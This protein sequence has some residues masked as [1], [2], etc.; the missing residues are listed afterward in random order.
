MFTYEIT[1]GNFIDSHTYGNVE[2]V[3]VRAN[4][5]LGAV[6]EA[7]VLLK[8]RFKNKDRRD[9]LRIARVQ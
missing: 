7:E 3:K 1:F 6:M 5:F 9:I 2:H 8:A 4:T